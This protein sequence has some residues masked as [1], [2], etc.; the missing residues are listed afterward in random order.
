MTH[1]TRQRVFIAA[2]PDLH[3]VNILERSLSSLVFSQ[4]ERLR[5]LPSSN[6]HLTLR[7]IGNVTF[8]VTQ[9]AQH[10][11][12]DVAAQHTP[13]SMTF[14]TLALFPSDQHPRVLTATAD[15][16][17]AGQTLVTDLE[18]LCQQLGL[19]AEQRPWR[20]H[21]SLA[22]IRGRKPFCFAAKKIALTM[23]VTTL[24]LME[25]VEKADGRMYHPLAEV[26]LASAR[27]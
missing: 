17:N 6:W 18:A 16:S 8:Q 11:L 3:T 4:S 13:F 7:F 5:W 15:T 21:I 1:A 14:T 25:S 23:Q 24:C 12:A 20:P 27:A 10:R 22:R 9:E 19:P 2:Q 26:S